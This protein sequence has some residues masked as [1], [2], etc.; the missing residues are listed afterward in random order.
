MTATIVQLYPREL[1]AAGDRGN[2]LALARRLEAAG[3]E[4]EAVEYSRGDT[5]PASADLVVIG[6]GPLSAMRTVHSDLLGIASRLGEWV[7]DGVPVFAYGAGAELLG[8]G[9]DLLDGSRLAGIGIFPLSVTRT[10]N[11]KVGYIIVDSVFGRLVGFEDNASV[12]TP[13]AGA[14]PLGTVTAGV[15]NGDGSEGV[16]VGISI[17]TQLG[18]PVLPLNPE[19]TASLVG[20]VAAR[21]GVALTPREANPL[22]DYATNA[23]AVI[24][25]NAT[26]HFSRI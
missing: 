15:G 24:I 3:V 14:T 16:T 19:L 21:R 25:A 4:T 11:R 18:G 8:H 12:W 6:N 22:D 23:R 1:G 7:A 13:D 2:V 5:L 26:H 17:A 10:T 20:A 9:V